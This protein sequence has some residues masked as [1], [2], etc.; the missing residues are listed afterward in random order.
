MTNITPQEE[1]ILPLY[2]I[3]LSKDSLRGRTR[4]QKLIFLSQKALKDKVNY[5]FDKA[6]F[7]PLSYHLNSIMEDLIGMGLVLQDRDFT[8]SGNE[9]VIYNLTDKGKEFLDFSLQRNIISKSDTTSVDQVYDEYGDMPYV[10]LLDRVHR[11][12]PEYVEQSDDFGF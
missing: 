11:D 6:P 9:V 2:L 1:L 5:N 4:L 7:G 12:Y 3:H 8:P 10:D